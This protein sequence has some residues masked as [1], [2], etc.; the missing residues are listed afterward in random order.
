MSVAI[1]C[2][3]GGK[4]NEGII[5]VSGIGT[6]VAPP[7]TVQIYLYFKNVSETAEEAKK[8]VGESVQKVLDILKTE[9]ITNNNIQTLSLSYGTENEYRDGRVVYAGQRAEQNIVIM[10]DDIINSPE[11]LP[12]IL[13]KLVGISN[14]SV[15]NIQFSVKDKT[16]FFKQ[17]RELAIQK[18]LEK[19]EQY[20][21]LSGKKITGVQ[22]INESNGR[23]ARIVQAKKNTASVSADYDSGYSNIPAG[24][25]EITTEIRVEYKIK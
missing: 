12:I 13:D 11:K 21:G 7:D 8:A 4:N 19:A 2:N 24:E 17:S 20:A 3:S 23:D 18:A 22:N 15:N 6:V 14:T 1:A 10:I 16:E 5:S 9:N 25:Q